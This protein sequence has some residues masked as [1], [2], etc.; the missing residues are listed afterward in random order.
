MTPIKCCR[1]SSSSRPRS[2][3][4]TPACLESSRHASS[5][6]CSSA[7]SS[8]A[9]DANSVCS[10]W[11]SCR[12]SARLAGWLG[13][14]CAPYGARFLRA[15]EER[16]RCGE[17]PAPIA[18]LCGRGADHSEWA[19]LLLVVPSEAQVTEMVGLGGLMHTEPPSP[20]V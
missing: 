11:Q 3:Q 6:T 19:Q 9:L 5:H 18:A 14:V 12:T 17:P 4:T 13:P 1:L 10:Q 8:S 20:S 16:V 15:G 7:S 2:A